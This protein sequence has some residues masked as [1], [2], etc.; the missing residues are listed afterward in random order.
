[1]L[2]YISLSQCMS[3][4]ENMKVRYSRLE[5]VTTLSVSQARLS[6]EHS[7]M[8]ALLSRVRMLMN[9]EKRQHT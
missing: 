6:L 3:A 8:W 9:A 5:Y 1:M 4:E 7:A 2:I